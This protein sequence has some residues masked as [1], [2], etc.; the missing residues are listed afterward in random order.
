MKLWIGNEPNP[1]DRV[2][3]EVDEDEYRE[4][5]PPRDSDEVFE[6]TDTET[7]AIHR[8]QRIPC[9]LGCRCALGFAEDGKHW[10]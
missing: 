9:G 10:R 2:I 6:L 3:I 5:Y 8:L 7:G 1:D 4:K